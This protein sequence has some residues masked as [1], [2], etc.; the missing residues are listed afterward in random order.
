MGSWAS[1]RSFF[2]RRIPTGPREPVLVQRAARGVLHTFTLETTD[3]FDETIGNALIHDFVVRD[4]ELLP[5]LDLRLA[6]ETCLTLLRRYTLHRSGHRSFRPSRLAV[7]VHGVSSAPA[8]PRKPCR[9]RWAARSI[10]VQRLTGR[11]VPRPGTI[12][13]TGRCRGYSV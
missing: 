3:Q 2:A 13:N 1:S 8:L 5:D 10:W 6:G 11:G 9:S 12:L 4:L 7:V